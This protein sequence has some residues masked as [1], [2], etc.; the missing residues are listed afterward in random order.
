MR[1]FCLVCWSLN[2]SAAGFDVCKQVRTH[3]PF[4]P[5]L[6]AALVLTRHS[7]CMQKSILI[8]KPRRIGSAPRALYKNGTAWSMLIDLTLTLGVHINSKKFNC[9]MLVK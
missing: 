5:G 1:A 2:R 7:A 9:V 6:H 3:M 4:V 8:I